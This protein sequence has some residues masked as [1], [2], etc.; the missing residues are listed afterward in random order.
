MIDEKHKHHQSKPMGQFV[1]C[2]PA[3][4]NHL[5]SFVKEKNEKKLLKDICGDLGKMGRG[6]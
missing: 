5:F 1:F 2:I 6:L 4:A 3:A